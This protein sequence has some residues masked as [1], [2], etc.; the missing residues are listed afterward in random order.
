MI[1]KW[2]GSLADYVE[3]LTEQTSQIPEH[4]QYYI[5]Y[6]RMG[7]DMELSGDFYTIETS[8]D[9]VHVFWSH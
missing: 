7:R 1:P 6:D 4:L 9:D 2:Y 3:E 8:F 5:D